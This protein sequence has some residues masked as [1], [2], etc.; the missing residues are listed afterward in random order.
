MDDTPPMDDTMTPPPPMQNDPM[1]GAEEPPMDEPQ[2]ENMG[3]ED[4]E[5]MNVINSLS[6]EDKAAVLKYAK[7]MSDNDDESQDMGGNEPPMDEPQG[8]MPPMGESRVIEG[9]KPSV[10]GNNE[11]KRDKKELPKTLKNKSRNPYI[12]KY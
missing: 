6:T 3:G 1:M 10:N 5:L 4:D 8:G 11:R 7:S 2:D 9:L 12:S